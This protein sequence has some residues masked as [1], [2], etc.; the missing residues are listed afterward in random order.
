MKLTSLNCLEALREGDIVCFSLGT[1]QKTYNKKRE[2]Q[3]ERN[4]SHHKLHL[5]K[6]KAVQIELRRDPEPLS[7]VVGILNSQLLN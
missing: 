1:E 4:F 3:L 2:N 7:S 5:I 6:T